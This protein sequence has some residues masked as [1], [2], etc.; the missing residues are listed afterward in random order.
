MAQV[1]K[2]MLRERF[3][4]AGLEQYWPQIE[5]VVRPAIQ[6]H[7]SP[8]SEDNLAIG[9]SKRSGAPDVP[10]DFVWPERGGKPCDFLCQ[11]NLAEAA[12]FDV[13]GL[14]PKAGLLSFFLTSYEVG[15]EGEING[16]PV[17]FFPPEI[18]LTRQSNE[19]V[20]ELMKYSEVMQYDFDYTWSSPNNSKKLNFLDQLAHERDLFEDISWDVVHS[21][22]MLGHPDDYQGDQE[23]TCELIYRGVRSN[24]YNSDVPEN[25]IA[26]HTEVEQLAF[27]NWLSLFD[28]SDDPGVFSLSYCIRR[29]DLARQDFSKTILIAVN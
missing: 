17:Y 20:E 11:I 24:A 7:A 22:C 16:D 15:W 2:E 26:L 28:T 14:L 8:C 6:V 25:W 13:E 9:A 3:V 29:D 27:D 23:P 1:T 21:E 19:R 4:E 18:P 12:P 10:M 5:R